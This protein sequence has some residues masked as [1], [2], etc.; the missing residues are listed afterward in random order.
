MS[1]GGAAPASGAASDRILAYHRRRH[2]DWIALLAELVNRES[3]TD[4]KAAVD[5][6]G[7]FL[8]ARL[9]T[10]GATVERLPQ[11]QYG[12]LL[13]A[14]WGPGSDERILILCHID[15]VWPLGEAK[16]R[17]FSERDGRL[18]GP[19][20]FDMKCGVMYSLA[21]LEAL[22]DLGLEPRR[23]LTLLYTTEEEIGSPA[24]RAVIEAEARRSAIAMCLEPSV[25]PRGAIKTSRSGV[26]R[27]DLHVKGRPSHSGADPKAGVSAVEELAR[28][29]LALHAFT[30]HDV[31]TTVNVGVV[32]G[33]TRPNV[34]AA[35]AAAEIDLRVRTMAEAARVEKAILGLRAVHPEAVV[36]VRGGLNRPPMERTPAIARLYE[37]ARTIAAGLGFE[38]P[39]AHT[40]GGSD[41]NLT[42]AAGTP[43]LD[44]LG[45]VGA[46]GH[47]YDEHVIAA[48]IPERLALFTQLLVTL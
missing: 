7:Q 10:L 31:G 20:V 47:A 32:R 34:V 16:R 3:P 11:A 37:Q 38:L 36:T 13:R 26:G 41:G 21:A 48:T 24:S 18:M 4:D 30:D 23:R 40:G 17:P 33:G 6:L 43:T 15:T 8:A 42:A 29:I 19:G 22:R 12:D 1:A 28:Q 39:E 46:G 25:P 5:A 45:A 2:R 35:E 44:G 9:Q 27:Y 14:E